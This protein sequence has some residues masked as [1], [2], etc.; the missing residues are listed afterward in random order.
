MKTEG[1]WFRSSPGSAIQLLA[2]VL[3]A[4]A[5]NVSFAGSHR[6]R[7][8]VTKRGTYVQPHRQTN[9]DGTKLNNWSTKGNVNPNIGKLGTK[10]P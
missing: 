2:A 8:H 9:P 6:V 4:L 1:K 3:L 5:L 7:G 10:E